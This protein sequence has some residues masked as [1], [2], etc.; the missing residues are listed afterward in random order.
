VQASQQGCHPTGGKQPERFENQAVLDKI[1][2]LKSRAF[3]KCG[4]GCK[5]QI[6]TQKVGTLLC[7]VTVEMVAP[8]LNDFQESLK[9]LLAEHSVNSYEFSA[10]ASKTPTTACNSKGFDHTEPGTSS[11]DDILKTVSDVKDRLTKKCGDSCNVAIDF[12]V[13]NKTMCVVKGVATPQ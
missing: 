3:A 10:I 2:Y 5:G 8:K 9:T 1:E 13:R 12:S 11:Y 4:H 7:L 6:K